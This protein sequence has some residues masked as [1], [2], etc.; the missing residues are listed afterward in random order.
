MPKVIKNEENSAKCPCP[1]CP[2]YNECSEG[3]DERLYCAAEVGKSGCEY[4]MNGCI[5]GPCSVH[6]ECGLKNG[7]YCVKGSAD[8]NG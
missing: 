6:V 8:D 2:S 7:Y 4:K 3:K 5:C 1:H